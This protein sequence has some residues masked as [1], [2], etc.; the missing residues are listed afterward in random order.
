MPVA[1][2]DQPLYALVSA[3]PPVTVAEV[4]AVMQQIETLLPN[5]DGL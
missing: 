1:A 3:T 5:S 2:A 4:I